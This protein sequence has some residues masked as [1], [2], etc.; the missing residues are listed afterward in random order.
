[1]AVQAEI[2][3]AKLQKKIGR[4]LRV[5]VDEAGGDG[6]IARSSADAPEIDGVVRIAD[7]ASLRPGQFV[8]VRVTGAGAHDL[9]AAVVAS[10]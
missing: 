10:L 5:L 3:A 2:S 8:E 1:M 6:A 7:G 4:T 9:E